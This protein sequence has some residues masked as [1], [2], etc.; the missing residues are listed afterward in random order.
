MSDAVL[1]C[2]INLRSSGCG[3]KTNQKKI[4]V[5]PGKSLSTDFCTNSTDLINANKQETGIK[6]I[7]F[8]CT[9]SS[10]TY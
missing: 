1:D 7:S 3:K 2:L 8:L 4:N 9:E 10:L 6:K 5:V